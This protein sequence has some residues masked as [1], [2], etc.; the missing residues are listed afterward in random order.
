[1][2]AVWAKEAAPGHHLPDDELTDPADT[3]PTAHE[4]VAP[5]KPPVADKPDTTAVADEPADETLEGET[6]DANIP[7]D[8]TPE[9]DAAVDDHDPQPE[10]RGS[11]PRT[12]QQR[13]HDALEALAVEALR[14]GD[15]G[16]HHG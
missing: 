10:A 16:T 5:D 1:M 3:T 6:V 13:N 4:A 12:Q 15:L 8:E 9:G 7:G 2:E 14:S 11:D